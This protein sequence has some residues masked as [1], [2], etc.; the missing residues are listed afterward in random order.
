MQE[1]GACEI[2]VVHIDWPPEEAHRLGY[3]GPL[4]LSENP[5]QIQNFLERDLAERVAM[6]LPPE[7]VTLTVEPGWGR[8][9]GYL[10]EMASHQQ[11]DLVVIGTHRRHGLD[12][13][14]FGSVSRRSCIMPM[15]PSR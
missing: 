10:F 13:L 1:I 7:K 6:I 14:R 8:T 11:V 3:H 5:D 4:P 15:S 9:E 12:R 2:N